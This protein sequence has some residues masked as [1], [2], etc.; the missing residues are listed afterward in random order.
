MADTTSGSRPLSTT[1]IVDLS[2]SL[3]GA[4]CSRLLSEEGATV[5]TVAP[6]GG[7]AD[8]RFYPELAD[9][10]Y[11]YSTIIEIDLKA[12]LQRGYELLD[13]SDAY[14]ISFRPGS[15]LATAFDP[16]RMI[17]RNARLVGCWIRGFSE[18]SSRRN[19]GAH[20]VL[21][22]ATAGII[23]AQKEPPR[24]PVVDLA[25]GSVAATRILAALLVRTVNGRGH[26]MQIAM[27]EIASAW[28][29]VG[30]RLWGRLFPTYGGF[31]TEDG[32]WI[33]L[34]FEHEDRQWRELCWALDL[35]DL[36]AVP[37]ADRQRDS[38]RLRSILR[39]R[40]AGMPS[41]VLERRLGTTGVAWS[42]FH[43]PAVG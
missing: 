31:R 3:P 18:S 34:G 39:D 17:E 40:I 2:S 16:A 13:A 20:D 29:T 37:T 27:D 41:E 26:A 1:R 19:L 22:Q 35:L 25:A 7:L 43:L 10:A 6:P 38:A 42:Y 33:A 4:Y 30:D 32:R 5:V 11:A 36:S 14:I 9:W 23:S 21:F 8:Q 15:S 12:E 24:V 28:A